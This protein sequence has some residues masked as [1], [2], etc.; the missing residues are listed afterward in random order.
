V[1]IILRQHSDASEKVWK[2]MVIHYY[3]CFPRVVCGNMTTRMSHGVIGL[4][5][6]Q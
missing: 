6:G 3:K 2:E 5:D 4:H 1:Y